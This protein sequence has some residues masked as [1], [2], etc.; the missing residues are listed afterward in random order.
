M[1]EYLKLSQIPNKAK[2]W[3]KTNGIC[4]Y[5]GIKLHPFRNFTIDHIIPKVEG[6]ENLVPCCKHCNSQKHNRNIEDFRRLK[7]KEISTNKPYTFWF[8][9]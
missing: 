7:I 9:R 8:E 2:V 5:C 4:W 1:S 6:I 3:G